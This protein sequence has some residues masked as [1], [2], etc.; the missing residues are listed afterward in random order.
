V[1]GESLVDDER[2]EP[3]L[4]EASL[5][6]CDWEPEYPVATYHSW[7][8]EAPRPTHRN[9]A[10]VR[11]APCAVDDLRGE[12]AIALEE[13]A[14]TWVASSNGASR[15]VSVEGDAAAAIGG[16]LTE[17]SAM[18]TPVEGRDAMALLA[19]AAASG[20]AHGRRRGMAAGRGTAWWTAAV[21][22]G[23]SDEWPPDPDA[24]GEA[25]EELE[26]W[27]WSTRGESGWICRIA[28]A[29]PIEGLAWALD[30]RDHE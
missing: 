25:I 2:A 29:D 15:A 24:L 16:L 10:A 5:R 27:T 7:K 26:W 28:I 1:R 19:W 6:L 8:V 9:G 3:H 21:L 11:I 4:A 14:R 22:A 12:E 20:G 17:G 13:V 18:A 30:A 23:T